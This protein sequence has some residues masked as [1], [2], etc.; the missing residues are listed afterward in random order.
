MSETVFLELRGP[1]GRVRAARIH[2]ASV[3][4]PQLTDAQLEA[5]GSPERAVARCDSELFGGR[6]RPS[7]EGRKGF[8]AW[9][10]SRDPLI[11]TSAPCARCIFSDNTDDA[12]ELERPPL[13]ARCS[14]RA[15]GQEVIHHVIAAPGGNGR[16]RLLCRQSVYIDQRLWSVFSDDPIAFS[17][18]VC[19]RCLK[20]TK[21]PWYTELQRYGEAMGK[22][23]AKV[24]G[25]VERQRTSV[26]ESKKAKR[27]T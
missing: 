27:V 17:G 18:G 13:F 19:E 2:M 23:L 5:Q 9:R 12:V 24:A 25:A 16:Y 7:S 22:T 3:R 14:L 15:F 11:F 8:A 1:A 10:I 20:Q 6:V 21:T 4:D 26:Y